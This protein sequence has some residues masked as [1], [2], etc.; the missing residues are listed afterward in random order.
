MNHRVVAIVALVV[1]LG[2]C[3]PQPSDAPP[4]P[5]QTPTPPS[6]RATQSAT[7][8]SAEPAASPSPTTG[9]TASVGLA[10]GEVIKRTDPRGASTKTLAAFSSATG[11]SLYDVDANSVRTL[12]EN[13]SPVARQPR[14]RSPGLVS[15]VRNRVPSDDIHLFGQDSLFEVDLASGVGEEILRLPNGLLGYDW[16]PDGTLL[17]Y[18]LL[19]DSPAN[20]LCLFD[21]R[22]GATRALRS[23]GPWAGREG[24]AHDDVS[25]AWSAA[26][27]NVLVVDTVEEPAN[28]F[29]VD[30]DGGDVVAPRDGT[31]ARWLA[32][33]WIAFQKDPQDSTK[34]WEWFVVST[35][36][37]AA[38]RFGLPATA[39]RPEVSPDGTM[40]AFDDGDADEPS[41][42]VFDIDAGTTRRIARGYGRRSGW[43]PDRSPRR[44][45][46]HV[47]QTTCARSIGTPRI[48]RPASTPRPAR[49]GSL[50]CR[51]RS[52]H[53]G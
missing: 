52:S 30:L 53:L 35:A 39:L 23:L 26:A 29:V 17:A 12:D 13:G 7:P 51:R 47:H 19:G 31:F 48:K 22:I 27:T 36:T 6:A 10:C 50:R 24:N 46:G 14:F 5:T 38:Q 2:G 21:S 15:F 20:V 4:T 16:S 9:Q 37:D 40:I 34:A 11:V 32:D 44:R 3:N 1:T 28:V 33:G 25:L 43:V 49:R 45:P 42:F 8:P 41:V 18:L